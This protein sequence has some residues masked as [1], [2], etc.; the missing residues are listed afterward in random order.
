MSLKLTQA[1]YVT[2]YFT[3]RIGYVADPRM[4]EKFEKFKM[5]KHV[6]DTYS[7]MWERLRKFETLEMFK[8]SKHASRNIPVPQKN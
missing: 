6:N 7:D 3:H 8:K 2:L 4:F 5:S 1:C